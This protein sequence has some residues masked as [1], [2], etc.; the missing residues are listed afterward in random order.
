MMDKRALRA[1]L[2]AIRD[3]AAPVSMVVPAAFAV[4]LSPGLIVASYVA[5]GGE[6]DPTPLARA[7]A[8]AGCRLALPHVVDRPTPIRFLAAGGTLVEGPFGLRQPG[9]D[10][11]ELAP[12][13]ILTPLVGFDRRGNRLGQGAGHYD[14]AFAAYPAAWRVGIAHAVQELPLL[15]P[16]PWDI[17]LHAIL[18]EQEW[19][20]P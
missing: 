19:I 15:I 7:A 11:A 2:R 4:R 8:D 17:P 14:R 13:I 10:A 18:T 5:M 3:A 9:V 20:V 6:V 1:R 12:D 16:D